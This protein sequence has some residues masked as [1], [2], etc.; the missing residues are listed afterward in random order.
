[1]S[2]LEEHIPYAIRQFETDVIIPL[3]IFGI[4][5]SF[6]TSSLAK[7]TTVATV[8]GFL[9]LATR[10][11]ATIPNRLQASAEMVYTF[12]VDTVTKV[13]GP[14][15]KRSVPFI[16]TMF[17]FIWIGTLIGLTPV[18]D[19]FTSHLIVTL[20]LST[21]T[22]VYINV[23]AFRKHGAGFFRFFLPADIPIFVAPIFVLVETVSYLFRPLTLGFRIFAN[24]VAGHIMLK[25][26]ADFCAM[27][28]VAL[29]SIGIAASI[30]P[31]VM[32]AILYAFEIM[33]VSIQ[34]YIFMLITCVY[35]RD[36]LRPH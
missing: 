18:K 2:G 30:A 20:A 19:T 5:V 4:D 34:S 3:E 23:I 35:L 16:F 13:S 1:M 27:L 8:T 31:L 36:A 29:G 11:R 26:F 10:K 33:I 15:G 9:M 24:I 22:F 6:T 21:A 14:E 25:L 7:V 17:I 28:V 32:I 12:V